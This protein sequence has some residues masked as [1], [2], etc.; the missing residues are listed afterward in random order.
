M[1]IYE[2]LLSSRDF[3]SV[4]LVSL[5]VLEISYGNYFVRYR[6]IIE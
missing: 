6:E 5:F 1:Y 4:L 3:V 2:Y